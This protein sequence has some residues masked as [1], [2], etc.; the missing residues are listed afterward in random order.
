[1][2]IYGDRGDLAEF[3]KKR[4]TDYGFLPHYMWAENNVI[5]L[6]GTIDLAESLGL[7][8]VVCRFSME[9]IFQLFQI[10]NVGK[11]QTRNLIRRKM[12]VSEV[13]E[14]GNTYVQEV[15]KR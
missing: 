4:N 5:K 15:L 10:G 12:K 6:P 7:P 9:I 3:G 8:I 14:T 2:S 13:E 11:V 1:M